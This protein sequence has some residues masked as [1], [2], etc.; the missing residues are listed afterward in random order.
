MQ[1]GGGG[2]LELRRQHRILAGSL[3]WQLGILLSV[4]VA[5]YLLPGHAF[6][7]RLAGKEQV[8]RPDAL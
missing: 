1:G 2:Y 7:Q 6:L 5:L 4:L 3:S 8:I